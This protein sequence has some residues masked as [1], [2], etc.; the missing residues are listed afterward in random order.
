MSNPVP[1]STAS[2]VR[3]VL[4]TGHGGFSGLHCVEFLAGL[5]PRPRIVGLGRAAD[6][7]GLV[8]AEYVGPIADRD[9]LL[10]ALRDAQPEVV[11]H[12]AGALP[13]A[14]AAELWADNVG[15][16]F[17]LLDAVQLCCP[18]A[19]VL[20]VGSAAEYGPTGRQA[21]DERHASQPVSEYGR[22]KLAQTLLCQSLSAERGLCVVVARAFNL[23]GPGMAANTVVG[24]ACSQLAAGTPLDALRLGRLDSFRDFLDIRDAVA[25][26]W[27][28]ALRGEPGAVYNV[29]SG[30]ARQV[31]D[32]IDVLLGLH[33]ALPGRD[34][35][36]AR[37]VSS[38]DVD[39]SCG[40]PGKLA[41]LLGGLALRDFEVSLRE[42][43]DSFGAFVPASE[44]MLAGAMA[45][46]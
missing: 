20:V 37:F 21:V 45:S 29:C 8:D 14:P 30:R 3:S 22:S 32:V 4:V 1:A 28:L 38:D 12:L 2:A 26:Y 16:A 7:T 41:A 17:H 27:Q 43:L 31:G 34:Q 33:G 44:R 18:A 39:Y 40:D 36:R 6:R 10:R 9:L 23:F 19:R 42:T 35:A 11:I 5:S 25:L 13:P 15:G 46:A 24:A